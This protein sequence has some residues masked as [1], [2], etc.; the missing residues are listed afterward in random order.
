MTHWC[1][2]SRICTRQ[3]VVRTKTRLVSGLASMYERGGTSNY[4]GMLCNA[5]TTVCH[6]TSWN[7]KKVL[8]LGAVAVLLPVMACNYDGRLCTYF[9]RSMAFFLPRQGTCQHDFV[10]IVPDCHGEACVARLSSSVVVV[11][12]GRHRPPRNSLSGTAIDWPRICF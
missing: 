12:T 11:T 5:P 6:S 10:V 9:H 4:T 8:S 7:S 2:I 3:T 1:Q